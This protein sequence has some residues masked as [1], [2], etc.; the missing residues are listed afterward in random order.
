MTFDFK[1]PD[2]IIE[3]EINFNDLMKMRSVNSSFCI[4]NSNRDICYIVVNKEK[5]VKRVGNVNKLV[6]YTD[7]QNIYGYDQCLIKYDDLI[8][9]IISD[10]RKNK[11]KK[12][13]SKLEIESYRKIKM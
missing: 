12:L 3:N 2:T 11:I 4:F 5:C 10:Y 9:E 6:G 8:K 13:C 7:K 1:I